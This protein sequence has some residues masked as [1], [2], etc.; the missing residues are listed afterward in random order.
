[1]TDLGRFATW[2]QTNG[3]DILKPTSE[4]EAIRYRR[5]D[6]GVCV[7]HQKKDGSLTFSPT[8]RVHFKAFEAGENMK[9]VPRPGVQHKRS[10]VKK[11]IARDGDNCCFCGEHLE[12]DD[13]TIEHLVPHSKGGKNH[14]S[15]LALADKRCNMLAGDM[16]VMDKIRLR[17]ELRLKQ[18]V[19]AD[20]SLGFQHMG[21]V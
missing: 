20:F 19:A 5:S 4:W 18:L 16:D 2:L 6:Y 10:L 14:M 3:A 7:I 17:D 11:I 15:N 13:T 12:A 8:S 9:K 21:A 1:M